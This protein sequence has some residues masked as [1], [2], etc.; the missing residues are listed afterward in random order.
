MRILV[1]EDYELL[2]D[3]IVQGTG[4]IVSSNSRGGKVLEFAH[5]AKLAISGKGAY[6]STAEMD[7]KLVYVV[8]T[9]AG[10]RMMT[11]AE[12]RAAYAKSLSPA[13]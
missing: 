12:F 11:P 10:Q 5:Q 4:P 8:V 13:N 2:R 1:V 3:S 6:A 7:D 9:Q